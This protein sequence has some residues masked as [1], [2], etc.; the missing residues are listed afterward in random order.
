MIRKKKDMSK[1]EMISRPDFVAELMRAYRNAHHGYFSA[2]DERNKRPSRYLFLA[3]GDL[4]AE[5]MADARLMVA[6]I[7]RRSEYG[8]MEVPPNRQVCLSG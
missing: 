5:I 4:P 1:E 2:A 7:R 8:W 3:D 6:R